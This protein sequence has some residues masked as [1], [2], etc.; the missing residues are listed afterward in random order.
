MA[1]TKLVMGKDSTIPDYILDAFQKKNEKSQPDGYPTLDTN[2]HIPE[3]QL[4]PV[5]V[6]A[7]HLA[8]GL[9]L[10]EDKVN[11]GA[12][13]GYAPLDSSSK[14]P[15]PN[16]P[17]VLQEPDANK[18][19]ISERGQ[20][21]GYVPLDP[22]G[23][24]TS[25]YLPP[26]SARPTH[27]FHTMLDMLAGGSALM[28]G[29]NAVI[30]GDPDADVN[31]EY[32]VLKDHPSL[33]A[34]FEH[35]GAHI[36][37]HRHSAADIDIQVLGNRRILQMEEDNL[38]STEAIPKSTIYTA[39]MLRGMHVGRLYSM[40]MALVNMNPDATGSPDFIPVSDV[41]PVGLEH[42]G[43]HLVNAVLV[44]T[45]ATVWRVLAEEWTGTEHQMTLE[46]VLDLSPDIVDATVIGLVDESSFSAMVFELD[47][48]IGDISALGSSTL[49]HKVLGLENSI[50][51]SMG[52]ISVMEAAGVAANMQGVVSHAHV[53]AAADF[54]LECAPLGTNVTF[55]MVDDDPA[56]HV[57]TDLWDGTE[58]R[59]ALTW[60]AGH[61][62][63]DWYTNWK[64]GTKPM[65][66]ISS[67]HPAH[68]ARLV[69]TITGVPVT[70]GSIDHWISGHSVLTVKWD[71][72]SSSMKLLGVEHNT[73]ATLGGASTGVHDT[74]VLPDRALTA[75]DLRAISVG[76]TNLFPTETVETA[77]SSGVNIE[78][79]K[80]GII[81]VVDRGHKYVNAV[82]IRTG[83]QTWVV[84]GQEFT[85]TNKQQTLL[86]NLDLDPDWPDSSA[87]GDVGS[88]SFSSITNDLFAEIGD[89]TMLG[90]DTLVSRI[91]H[92]EVERHT[93]S[94]RVA[95]L[96]G[97]T[98]H[99]HTDIIQDFKL[100]VNNQGLHYMIVNDRP[101]NP[102]H[103]GKNLF[104]GTEHKVLLEWDTTSPYDTTS[105]FNPANVV[106]GTDTA[107]WETGQK[108][109][110]W[111]QKGSAFKQLVDPLSTQV[112]AY[113]AV[114]SFIKLGS[115]LTVKWDIAQERLDVLKVQAPTVHV[116]TSPDHQPLQVGGQV[117]AKSL[118]FVSLNTEQQ[119][120]VKVN[121][122]W[123]NELQ[124][125]QYKDNTGS[126]HPV[127]ETP[128]MLR[129]TGIVDETSVTNNTLWLDQHGVVLILQY[130]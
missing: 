121:S 73:A 12:A 78:A 45:E 93:L 27:L 115:I 72:T 16:L 80:T 43:L 41:A 13:N 33:P 50:H 111:I 103:I 36:V 102:D 31:G 92:N 124:V 42:S 2:G 37:I 110:V 52:R 125:L 6:A 109:N 66:W 127:L 79:A 108:P 89:A 91:L 60:K 40:P 59:I 106:D 34:D 120:H 84:V 119:T 107:N 86:W 87:I 83:V 85:D 116:V 5:E 49:V 71:D 22:R 130:L 14:V 97:G 51:D 35:Q 105:P 47:N 96:E 67:A 57:G 18:Q 32:L 11:K 123:L 113:A 44:R 55:L 64:S 26:A 10:K 118:P 74:P 70:F 24:I 19:D 1:E 128:S 129:L 63:A 112:F 23:K 95:T 75:G 104:D 81:G 30:H 8:D 28:V 82:M 94:S 46:W 7:H 21:G 99:G 17:M 4:P 9:A 15:L 69:D 54:S 25:Q 38:Y 61:D 48:E 29:E 76:A 20:A 101:T 53:V 98:A 88:R 100:Q 39:E 3:G 58:H 126:S 56:D 114:L 122:I 77:P 62:T 117:D 65:V 68:F 90:A